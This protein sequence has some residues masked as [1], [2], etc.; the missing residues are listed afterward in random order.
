M[1]TEKDLMERG[2]TV[3]EHEPASDD[4]FWNVRGNYSAVSQLT[5]GELESA[6]LTAQLNDQTV[7]D[8]DVTVATPPGEDNRA[9]SLR[10]DLNSGSYQRLDTRHTAEEGTTIHTFRLI[11]GDDTVNAEVS[12]IMTSGSARA[13]VMLPYLPR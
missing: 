6:L 5:A 8:F 10:L 13:I 4:A 12:I 7:L 3:V 9:V 2:G 11:Q 1:R